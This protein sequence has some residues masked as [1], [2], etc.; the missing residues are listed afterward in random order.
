MA[1]VFDV[2]TY[3]P[4]LFQARFVYQH[5]DLGFR[6]CWFPA[7]PGDPNTVGEAWISGAVTQKIVAANGEK[8][9]LVFEDEQGEVQF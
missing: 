1:D 8:V 6:R 9:T 7:K 3:D 4:F 5:T 2:G